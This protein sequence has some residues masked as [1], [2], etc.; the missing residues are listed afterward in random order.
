[1]VV[2]VKDLTDQSFRATGSVPSARLQSRNFRSSQ[3]RAAWINCFAAIATD[4]ECKPAV[5]ADLE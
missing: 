1:M 2:V 3:M 5:V 4:R